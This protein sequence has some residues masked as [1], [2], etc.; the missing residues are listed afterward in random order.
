[1]AKKI[2]MGCTPSTAHWYLSFV[3]VTKKIDWSSPF[4][5]EVEK[6]M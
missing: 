1:M 2:P 5:V 4:C 3:G 6:K